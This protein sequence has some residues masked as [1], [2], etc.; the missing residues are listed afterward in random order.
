LHQ[1]PKDE[2]EHRRNFNDLQKNKNRYERENPCKRVRHHIRAQNARDRPARS[3]AGDRGLRIQYRV[4]NSRAQTADQVK[5]EVREMAQAVLNV[6]S[7]NP[8][9]PHVA[10]QMEPASMQEYRSEER[11]R[12]SG[13]GNMRLW[14]GEYRRRNNSIMHNESFEAAASKRQFV[15]KDADI[16]YDDRDRDDWK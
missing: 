7:E 14:P 16:G 6:V 8:E 13:K 10:D 2:E 15:K 1:E 9:V 4:D 12:D 11:Q 5:Y 3:D